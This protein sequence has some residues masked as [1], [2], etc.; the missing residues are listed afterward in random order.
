MIVNFSSTSD[1]FMMVSWKH[2][3]NVKTVITCRTRKRLLPEIIAQ[4]EVA[5]IGQIE[6]INGSI[7]LA[8]DWHIPIRIGGSY[9]QDITG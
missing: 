9:G 5:K 2:P 3:G 6:H 7:V 1:L 4:C 8:N